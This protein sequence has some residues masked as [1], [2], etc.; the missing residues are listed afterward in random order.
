MKRIN[1]L[2]FFVVSFSTSLHAQNIDSLFNAYQN[3]SNKITQYNLSLQL[4]KAYQD[5]QIDSA[6]LFGRNSLMLAET[7]EVAHYK[8]ESYQQL[9]NLA[10][11]QDNFS[12]ADSLYQLAFVFLEEG[13]SKTMAYIYGFQTKLRQGKIEEGIPYLQEIR[14][15]IGSDTTSNLMIEYYSCFAT[16]FKEKHDM[17]ES[18]EYLLKA[19]ELVVKNKQEGAYLSNINY[20]LSIAFEAAGAYSQ[21]LEIHKESQKI[22]QQKG[23]EDKELFALYGI[24]STLAKMEQYEETK[25]SFFEAVALK[26]QKNISVAFGFAYNVMG[27]IYLEQAQLDSA[28]Y[29]YGKGIEIS[30][31]QNENK[32]LGENYA[33]MALSMYAKGDKQKAK[34]YAEQTQLTLSYLNTEMNS[35]LATLYAEELNY[36]TAYELLHVNWS[37][38]EEKE[39]NEEETRIVSGLLK[40]RFEQGKLEAEAISQ[41]KLKAQR[42][43]VLIL[44]LMI[45]AIA[46][47]LI[48]FIQRRNALQK[49]DLEKKELELQRKKDVEQ[50][51]LRLEQMVEERTQ[52]LQVQNQQLKQYAFIVAHDLKEPLCNVSGMAALL[53]ENYKHQLDTT[54]QHFLQHVEDSTQYMNHLL[55]DLLVY[56][57]LSKEKQP[58]TKTTDVRVSLREAEVSL[59]NEIA[60]CQA[61]IVVGKMPQTVSISSNH[62]FLLFQNLLSNALQFRRKNIPTLIQIHCHKTEG[63]H[64]FEVKDN[65]IGIS[66]ENQQKIFRIFHRL[67]KTA[68]EGT[69]IGLAICEKIVQLYGGEIGVSSSVNKGSIFYFALPQF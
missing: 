64:H 1:I 4:S 16:Y 62:L 27:S 55:E 5:E 41:E 21:A 6:L 53:N 63:Y 35:L 17:I 14:N 60:E 68:F 45:I 10:Y 18:L 36:K 24:M 38:W 13:E 28:E 69:G 42:Q 3:T 48:A 57:T 8:G 23:Q 43:W 40:D 47:S 33:G 31:L 11:Q 32:E 61:K 66:S 52:Q 25:K 37:D 67:D 2:L 15:F 20:S 49:L 22:A 54:A 30:K 58:D 56:A 50:M 44:I 19:K 12:K 34:W 29:Y 9:G 59:K 46:M 65:G 51:N 26:E 39:E 7:F